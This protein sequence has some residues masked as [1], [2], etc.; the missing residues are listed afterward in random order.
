MPETFGKQQ[1]DSWLRQKCGRISGSGMG[2]ATSYLKNGNES[3]DRRNYRLEL[4]AARLTGLTPNHFVTPGMQWG[5]EQEENAVLMY[6][7]LFG[8]MAEPCGFFVHPQ[9]DFSGA[10]PD[11]LIGSDGLLECKAPETTTH[12]QWVIEGKVPEKYMPQLQW[13]MACTGREWA[14]F[15]SFDPRIQDDNLR[16][17]YRRVERDEALIAKYTDEVLK[18]EEEINAFMQ[19]HGCTPVAPFPVEI[20]REDGEVTDGADPDDFSGPAYNFLGRAEV[21]P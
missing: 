3:A 16:F 20:V 9:H 10:S 5:I 4:I 15:L 8:V 21:R 7:S 6:E 2:A 19:Q 17:F 14:D 18:L 13:E 1:G 11:R 12:L